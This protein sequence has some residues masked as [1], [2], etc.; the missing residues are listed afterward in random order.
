MAGQATITTPLGGFRST[1]DFID[2][3]TADAEASMYYQEV[4]EFRANAAIT[5]GEALMFVAPTATVPV[6][7]TPMTAAIT[8]SDP[9]AFAGAAL[10]AAA[11]G[12]TVR[13]LRR[14]IARVRIDAA[15]TAAALSVLLAPDT[16][17]GRFAVKTD[18]VA[19]DVVVGMVLGIEDA[20][21]TADFALCLIDAVAVLTVVNT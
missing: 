13:V 7:V 20:S 10:N 16:T 17:T 6:S 1:S 3:M 18:P 11:A 5:Q 2:G 9:W 21:G 12:E 4:W 8:G 14:G 19:A 15:D